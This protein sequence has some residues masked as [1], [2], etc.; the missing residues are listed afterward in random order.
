MLHAYPHSTQPILGTLVSFQALIS[1]FLKAPLLCIFSFALAGIFVLAVLWVVVVQIQRTLPFITSI[2]GSIVQAI[3]LNP[4]ISAW[5]KHHPVIAKLIANRLNNKSVFGLTATVMGALFLYLLFVYI[6]TTLEFMK[7][8]SAIQIDQQLANLLYAYRDIHIVH[9]F[10]YITT[11]GDWKT[12][13]VLCVGALAALSVRQH[14]ALAAGLASALVGDVLSVTLLK[15]IFH[16]PRPELAYFIESSGSFPSG[17]AAISIA[18]FGMI[19]YILWRLRVLSAKV[20]APLAVLFAFL[21]G[22]SRLYLIEHYLSDVLN[23]YIVGALWLLIGI[24]LSEVWQVK[25]KTAVNIQVVSPMRNGI[26]IAAIMLSLF[27]ALYFSVSYQKPKNVPFSQ[28][29]KEIIAD[30]PSLF[31]MGKAPPMTET[32]MGESQEPINL[33]I[34]TK[35]RASLINAM[36]IAGWTVAQKP[37]FCTLLHA[38]FRAWSNSEDVSA[39]VTPYFWN[40]QPNFIGFEKPTKDKTLR[41]RHHVR[42]WITSFETP[43][44]QAIFIGTASFDDGLKWGITHRIDPNIDAERNFIAREL[45]ADG[46]VESTERFVTTPPILGHNFT[47]DAFFTDGKVVLLSLKK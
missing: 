16:R 23:G 26:A 32:I 31:S 39:P 11:L 38:G 29:E 44:G 18:F 6:G 20:A 43:N 46:L 45:V 34:V 19:F 37:G 12:I 1:I 4:Y 40:K 27:G 17:H 42:F 35:S 41:K 5:S 3:A 14:W 13:A 2:T 21:I 15:N 25:S 28:H 47:G 36:A 22:A 30:I 10:T 9:L 24:S 7:S 33:I 8:G